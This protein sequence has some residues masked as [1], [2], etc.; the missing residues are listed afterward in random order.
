MP[1]DRFGRLSVVGVPQ[2]FG[3][4]RKVLCRCDC[5]AEK[6]FRVDHL[7][8]GRTTSCGCGQ[9]EGAAVRRRTHGQTRTRLHSIWMG[10]RRRCEDRDNPAYPD[11]GGRGITVCARWQ[12]FEAFAADMGECPPGMTLERIENGRGYE[13]GNC[14]WRTP[15]DQSRNKRNN[16]LLTLGD[17]T[18]CLADWAAGLGVSPET[19]KGRLRRGWAL[20]RALSERAQASKRNRHARA[21]ADVDI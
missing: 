11:Y 20:S 18:K 19:I 21:R 6:A 7:A 17:T 4:H 1:A 16:V 3:R 15:R 14:A 8:S 10:M 2:R 13:P 9:R 5:G 12:A